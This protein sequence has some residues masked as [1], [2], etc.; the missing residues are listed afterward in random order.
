MLK[1]GQ[2]LNSS[3]NGNSKTLNPRKL[4]SANISHQQIL[5]ATSVATTTTTQ[6]SANFTTASVSD[7]T[8]STINSIN[9]SLNPFIVFGANVAFSL[10]QSDYQAN[11]F[12]IYPILFTRNILINNNQFTLNTD[13][14]LIKDNVITLNSQL[15]NVVID[16]NQYDNIISGFTFPI[17]DYNA[18]TGYY[19]GLLYVPNS[20]IKQQSPNTTTYVWTNL[21][22]NYFSKINKGFFK[23]KYLPQSLDFLKY[24]NTMTNIYSDLTDNNN[25]L[26]NLLVG[27][28]AIADGELIVINNLS[29]DFKISDDISSPYSVFGIT[30]TKFNIYNDINIFFNNQ[31]SIVGTSPYITFSNNLITFFKN[32]NLSINDFNL[33][34]KNNLFIVSNNTNFINFDSVNN[35]IRINQPTQIQTLYILSE[36]QLDNVPL[37]FKTNLDII[38]D[39]IT[40]INFN[41]NNSNINLLK[42]TN[43]N[44]LIILNTLTMNPSSSFIFS[45]RFNFENS[46]N[47]IFMYLD[48]VTSTI[49]FVLPTTINVLNIP[50]IFNLLNNIPITVTNDFIVN[51]GTSNYINFNATQ[52]I[53]YTNL[54]I[55]KTLPQITFNS[56]DLLSI[57]NTT[58]FL[59]ISNKVI[60]LGPDKTNIDH[61]NNVIV[62]ASFEISNTSTYITIVPNRYTYTPT[63]NIYIT[64]G[65]TDINNSILFNFKSVC[66]GT[67]LSGTLHGTTKSSN[68]KQISVYQINLWTNIDVNNLYYC[69]YTTL[70][71]LNISNVGDWGINN[72]TINTNNNGTS[73]LLVNCY[74]S[75]TDIV[76]WSFKLDI[77]AI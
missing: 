67:Q 53:F 36:L 12:T 47:Q 28:I 49:Q 66:K 62:N 76:I 9:N 68:T 50:I 56:G 19:G 73:D 72:I 7:L 45:G 75:P 30:K 48:S 54:Y 14:F 31:L 52:S 16:N 71:P 70:T 33:T 11:N 18:D 23:L 21:K 39:G 44:D 32:I 38:G 17:A 58:S 59:N 57:N 63:N 26:S 55:N 37:T 13:E 69:E 40:Y 24:Q 65:I 41:S 22:F 10:L 64:S 35:L 6:T 27:S 4:I 3:A 34:F 15:Q 60:V 5:A 74:G 8:V 25:N 61:S 20:K 43:I 46:S 51:N 29:L 2:I 42:P 1:F 77:L